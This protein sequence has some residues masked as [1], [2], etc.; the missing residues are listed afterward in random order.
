[1]NTLVINKSILNELYDDRTFKNDVSEL[2]NSLIDSE[3]LKEEP[4][5]D[6][7]DEC[8]DAL[9]DL[10]SE[11]YSAVMPFIVK[12]KFENDEKKRKVLSIFIAAAVVLSLS[13]SAVAVGHTVEKKIEERKTENTTSQTAEHTTATITSATSVTVTSSTTVTE[14]IPDIKAVKLDLKFSSDFKS[15]YRPG[16]ELN[17]NG[18]S[19]IAGFSDRTSRKIDI[20]DCKIIKSEN[21][22]KDFCNE[23]ITVEYGGVSES[24]SVSVFEEFTGFEI[25][26]Y[27]GFDKSTEAPK[28]NS[29]LQ[30]VEMKTGE[31]ISITMR[32]NND[33]FVCVQKDNDNLADVSVSYLGGKDG[34]EIYL[35][36]T[37]GNEPGTTNVSLAYERSPDDIMAQVTVKVVES[38][39]ETE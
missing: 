32:K 29:T 19:V 5:F 23:K 25:T 28:I 33:G 2:I 17:L 22:G 11:K 6:F 16:E 1:M 26:R 31:S 14:T 4:D 18:M 9:I 3:L 37:A 7:I 38:D 35:N 10:Y 12:N 30:Y 21:F 13:F 34:R 39:T 27:T 20:N 36:I 15:E 8:A 24:F